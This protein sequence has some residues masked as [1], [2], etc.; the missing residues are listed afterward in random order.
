MTTDNNTID[1]T[2]ISLANDFC[3]AVHEAD[4]VTREQFIDI[5]LRLLPRL[6]VAM[7]DFL[8]QS[9]PDMDVIGSY[10]DEDHYNQARSGIAALMGEE[11]TFLETFM[12]DM[13]YS[14]TPIAATI[15]ESLADIYQDMYNFTVTI[16]ESEGTV[17]TEAMAQMHENFTLYWSKTLCNVMR[18]LNALKYLM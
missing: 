8:P 5:M 9:E 11:D 18:P 13:K 14:D 2:F 3:K 10:V 17:T 7:G 4:S 6:Y 16:K 1:I 15:S 12:D